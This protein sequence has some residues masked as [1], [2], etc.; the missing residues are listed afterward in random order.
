MSEIEFLNSY[1]DDDEPDYVTCKRYNKHWLMWI[2]GWLCTEE[3]ERHRCP[4]TFEP[5][6]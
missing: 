5:E 1:V 4:V 2:D 6:A 3:G